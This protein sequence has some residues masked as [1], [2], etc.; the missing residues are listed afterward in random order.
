MNHN[1]HLQETYAIT[2]AKGSS[3]DDKLHYSYFSLN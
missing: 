3:R 1:F 2:F